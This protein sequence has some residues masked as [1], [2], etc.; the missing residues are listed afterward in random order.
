MEGAE[1]NYKAEL[2]GNGDFAFYR[3]QAASLWDDAL[4]KVTVEGGSDDDRTIFYTALYHTMIDPRCFTA[5]TGEYP[6]A[7]GTA[8][9]T[10]RYTR[11]TVFSGWDVFRSQFPLQTII[12]PVVVSDMINSFIDMAEENGSG[13]Y[14]RW[15]LL[16]AYSGCMLGNPAIRRASNS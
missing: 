13:V 2:A 5:V 11:R 16:N 8:H 12:N 15:E 6:G 4:G 1:A 14:D 7:D 9:V 10:D 3:K